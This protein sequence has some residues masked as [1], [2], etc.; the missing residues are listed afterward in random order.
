MNATWPLLSPLEATS[1]AELPADSSG[2]LVDGVIVE[3]ELPDYLHELVVAWLVATLRSWAVPRGGVVGG[4][5][6]KF[7]LGPRLGRKPDVSVFVPPNL[8]PRRG[9]V[10]IPPLLMIEVLSRAPSDVR[11]DRI[12]K[13][14]EYEAFGVAHFWIVDPEAKTIE[15]YV[16]GDK[17][18]YER[19]FSGSSGNV[20]AVGF[21]GLVLD[22]DGLWEE[23]QRLGE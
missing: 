18:R 7:L 16:L 5:E 1:W 8:P 12:Q 17:G 9:P 4:S 20:E 19:A 14:A 3:E 10:T 21:E 13:T 6:A 22:L 15:G 2:E 23:G 11:R